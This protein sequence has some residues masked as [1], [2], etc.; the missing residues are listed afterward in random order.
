MN[1]NAC[2]GKCRKFGKHRN[3][4]QR[5]RCD[6]CKKT[7]TEEHS[8]LLGAMAVPED[9]AILALRLL[10]EGNSIR[11]TER[12][13]GVHRDTIIRLL[14]RTGENC[15]RMMAEGIKG[16]PV[17]DVQVDEI[18]GFVYKKETHKWFE[19]KDN[20]KI[21][22]AYTFVAIERNTKLVLTFL[23]G[24]RDI[25]TT[26]Q[27][28]EN[29]RTAT[30]PQRF[31]LTSDGFR[32]YMDAMKVRL[33]DKCDYGMLIKVYAPPRDGEQRY[34]PA[35]VVE[36]LPRVIMGHPERYLI[37]TSHVERQNLTM[38]MA[39]RRLTRLTNGF[40]K[41]WENLNAALALHFA[42]YNFCRVHQTIRVTPAMEAG[43]THHV[44]SLRKLVQMAE[45][46]QP[47]PEPEAEKITPE[48][49]IHPPMQE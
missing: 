23:L 10:I 27:F 41:K 20:K 44:W 46:F 42:H 21:G 33:W 30:G 48:V 5:F 28:I 15:G 35:D 29:V 49:P 18:W 8:R 37:C 38:R 6:K 16:I 1:C 31:Q 12:I 32:P 7:Y 14:I 22:D 40:S 26:N 25:K 43:I 9:K 45:T 34:S 47:E 24:R 17:K 36:A 2:K 11:S 3:G 13:T 4:L 19:E 39:M